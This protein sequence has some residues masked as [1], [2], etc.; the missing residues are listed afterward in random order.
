[1]NQTGV[2]REKKDNHLLALREKHATYEAM[3]K[4]EQKRPGR[5]ELYIRELKLKKLKVK[6]QLEET[7][8]TA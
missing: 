6:E 2:L 3:I 5:N 1:M 8:G 4:E 7:A